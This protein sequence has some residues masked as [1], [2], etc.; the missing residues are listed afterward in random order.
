MTP[1]TRRVLELIEQ[2]KKSPEPETR[3]TAKA[4]ELM[5]GPVTEG[6][7]KALD[8]GVPG[9]N[10]AG[11]A[12]MLTADAVANILV[13][14]PRH[15]DQAYI[16]KQAE[17]SHLLLHGLHLRGHL[18]EFLHALFALD[19]LA[20]LA[21][22]F[23]EEQAEGG[24]DHFRARRVLPQLAHGVDIVD[25]GLREAEGDAFGLCHGDHVS[26][27]FPR[28]MVSDIAGQTWPAC[29]TIRATSSDFV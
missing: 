20:R 7:Q 18:F 26:G 27:M 12:I 11:A 23:F 9:L 21:A 8:S 15:E 10:V 22:F 24:S 14:L 29:C 19:D 6:L 4:L 17:A 5:L 3:R 28:R 25:D 2:L 13:H 16:V 1:Q